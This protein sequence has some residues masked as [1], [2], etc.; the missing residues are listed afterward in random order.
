MP[1]A[2]PSGTYA[3]TDSQVAG[4]AQSAGFTGDGLVKAVAV[5]L[6]ETRGHPTSN[7]HN[8]HPPDDSYGPWQIN[9]LGPMGPARRKQF[10]LTSNTD[11]YNL[12]T[13]AKAAY[14][15]SS[16]G[17]NFTPWTTY[18]SGL[19][20]TYMSRARTAAGSPDSSGGTTNAQQTLNPLSIPGDITN[21][22]S[23]I[24]NTTTWLRLGMILA[25]VVLIAISLSEL[26]GYAGKV[27]AAAKT[28]VGFVPGGKAVKAA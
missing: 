25:G 8:S 6:A 26:S 4:A 9:M 24:T 14:A 7:A 21:F 16:G 10:G 18:T 5:A 22:F 27:Q 3:V 13:N 28:A 1:A 19:Y 11:L 23:F 12:N 15:I 2:T 20:I 17:K